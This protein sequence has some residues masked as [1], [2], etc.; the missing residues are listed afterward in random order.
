MKTLYSFFSIVI[1]F[2]SFTYTEAAET[3]IKA[4]LLGGIRTLD[5]A[6]IRNMNDHMVS[7]NI[8]SNLVRYKPGTT[9]VEPDLAHRWEVSSLS[10]VTTIVS[11]PFL[12]S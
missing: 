10:V 4:R 3:V 9:E 11:P 7:V 5:A 1:L 8:Y 2:F 12:S 6:K